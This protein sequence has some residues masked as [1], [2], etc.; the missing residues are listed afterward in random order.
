MES[1]GFSRYSP[2]VAAIVVVLPFCWL[3]LATGKPDLLPAIPV[4]GGLVGLYWYLACV[5]VEWLRRKSTWPA[6]LRT[7]LV[8]LSL[9]PVMAIPVLILALMSALRGK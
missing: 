6:T 1:A 8:W 2:L 3:T 7:L 4:V 9:A 5:L